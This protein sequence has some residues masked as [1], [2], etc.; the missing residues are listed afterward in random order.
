MNKRRASTFL[1]AKV[2]N[3]LVL[4]AAQAGTITPEEANSIVPMTVMLTMSGPNMDFILGRLFETISTDAYKAI[5][6][7]GVD[8]L[9]LSPAD[10]IVDDELV[11][12][13]AQAR[14]NRSNCS[15]L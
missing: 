12:T 5:T 11:S 7:T 14:Y 8:G 1:S 6:T 15:L 13:L 4:A 2:F 9:P 10:Y 3:P